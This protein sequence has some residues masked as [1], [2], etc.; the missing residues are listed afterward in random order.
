M[1]IEIFQKDVIEFLNSLESES[2]D[3]IFTD[4]LAAVA[5]GVPALN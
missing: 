1:D 4:P 3:M 5:M 2:V